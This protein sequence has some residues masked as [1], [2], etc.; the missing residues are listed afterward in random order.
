MPQYP[1]PQ[2]QYYSN[3]NTTP[4]SSY[5]LGGGYS[6]TYYGGGNSDRYNS[7][8]SSHS[9]SNGNGTPSGTQSKTVCRMDCRY[10][11]AVV[12]LRGMK[13]MLLA[14]TSVELYSTDH[15]P[16]SVQL[17]EKDYTTS[18]CKCKIRDVA[19]KVCGNVIGYHITQP[20][21]QCL[22]A[23]NNGHFWMFHTEGVVG[24]ERMNMDLGKL[25]Q[26]LVRFPHSAV[27]NDP[28]GEVEAA[29][30]ARRAATVG[31]GPREILGGPPGGVRNVPAATGLAPPPTRPITLT[32]VAATAAVGGDV[33]S[34]AST[35]RVTS[36][37]RLQRQQRLSQ[38][39]TTAT[40]TYSPPS[41]PPPPPLRVISSSP[42]PATPTPTTPTPTRT[43]TES[44]S[45]RASPTSTSSTNT[46][47]T[48]LDN[49]VAPEP[50]MG[51]SATAAL[52]TLTL[53]KFLQ[54]LKWEQLPHPDL[55]I[56]LD[57][58]TMGGEP[59]FAGDWMELVR[60][61]AETAAANMSLALD[62]VEETEQYM[63]RMMEEHRQRQV[64]QEMAERAE[65]EETESASGS[66]GG[67]G[68]DE[69]EGEG[70]GEEDVIEL[71]PDH[72]DI[73][74]TNVNANM[75]DI[76]IDLE[77]G[78]T[79]EGMNRLIHRVDDVALTSPSPIR[80]LLGE[81]KDEGEE[82]DM[83][84]EPTGR[85][86]T[87]ERR[88]HDSLLADAN[89]VLAP[90]GQQ[91][92]TSTSTATTTTSFMGFATESNHQRRR[93]NSLGNT[94][95]EIV[96]GAPPLHN[97]PSSPPPPP[98]S[99]QQQQRHRRRNSSSASSSA[100]SDRTAYFSSESCPSMVLTS[101]MI[102]K[103]SASAAAADAAAAANNLLF[104]RRSRRDYDMMCR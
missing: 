31:F 61:T 100:S 8:F 63:A 42:T 19:C 39:T 103:A 96:P 15:P 80:T 13:A 34:N 68:R 64:Q 41:Y 44:S 91:S 33:R 48:N 12:C 74:A 52:M 85:G 43:A 46:T 1:S 32:T 78:V 70:E 16:G 47:A 10:C 88:Q 71:P 86:R 6:S 92:T 14:D 98:P 65:L 60:Q 94:L 79:E 18:N 11:S 84:G 90:P 76:E 20:C 7:S 97:H 54:P 21:Q 75:T 38:T 77:A 101:A 9:I 35:T 50:S 53:S 40:T 59:L 17:I 29:T 58:N 30:A 23:P 66:E 24:Q 4:S 5:T 49:R 62:Q 2:Y 57:P 93:G 67:R 73:A 102:A 25:V 89:G 81:Y 36:I 27:D 87:L 72:D 104:G 99:S 69:G 37:S 28:A 82:M 55:D 26:E 3:I 95:S 51:P 45:S 22:K 83:N 56:D